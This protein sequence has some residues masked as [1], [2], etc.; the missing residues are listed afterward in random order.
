M[1]P[2]QVAYRYDNLPPGEVFRYL[3]L[4]PGVGQESLKCSLH[5]TTTANNTQFAAISYV[6]GSST[7]DESIICEGHI[8]MI[9]SN[10]AK[11]LRSVR[12]PDKP[13]KLW[14][15]SICINQEDMQ[16]KE[17]QV[18]F[19]GKLY[20][21]AERT[22]IYMGSDDDSQGPDVCS[23]LD[24]VDA[25][26]QETCRSID[27]SWDSFP[28]PEEDEQL[29]IDTRWHSFYVLL[30]QSWFDRGWVVQEA[31]LGRYCEVV[32]GQSSFNWDK[33]MHVYIWLSTRAASIYHSEPFGEV[34]INSHMDVYLES[35]VEF[36]R[37]F[38]DE[39][40]WGSP[41]ILR[42]LNCAKELAL[43]DPRDRI[44]AFTA[45]PQHSEEP[46]ELYPD[47]QSSYLETYRTFTEQYIRSNKSTELLDYV[48]HDGHP[49]PDIPS[50]VVRWDVPT[51]SIT[52]NCSPTS[53]L[54]PRTPSNLEPLLLDDSRLQVR[55]VVF[56]TVHY[57]SER[58]DWDTT[59]METIR[60]I[61]NSVITAAVDCPYT[62][63][64]AA[65]STRLD[66]FLDAISA[67]MYDGEYSESQQARKTFVLEAK[68]ER[69]SAG[70]N[71]QS[72][73]TPSS[74]HADSTLFFDPVR[75]RLHNKK[76]ILTKRGYMG[77]A[78][79]PACEGNLCG[80]I[81]GCKTPCLLQSVKGEQCYSYLG[82][83]A[84]M[85]KHAIDMVTGDVSFCNILGEEDSKD[86]IEWDVEEQNIFLC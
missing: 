80:I 76:F 66:A 79:S 36:G 23:L 15:D 83:T 82:A 9:T 35:H 47:Y 13:L 69:T 28:Y 31:A 65:K 18:A 1:S 85:G 22:L 32:W 8:M 68:L 26:I 61:W 33:F 58:F 30:S 44:Y 39:W 6:W 14:A 77:L 54:E 16:E 59:T 55:G 24:E 34:L 60:M 75:S 86:W 46:I 53:A 25:M 3:V 27:M 29:L 64:Y 2:S 51:W 72:N 20:Q 42:T 78:P 84:L 57:A 19:M 50:W 4:Q 56:D 21:T 71:Q 67:G 49:H 70:D 40:S 7:K 48:S 45:L 12:S 62:A 38:Y 10:L 5:T 81:F 73:D 52:R 37:A 43:G 74:T 17:H 63:T 11:V 41:S